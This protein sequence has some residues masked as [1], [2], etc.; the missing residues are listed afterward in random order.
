[1]KEKLC[2]YIPKTNSFTLVS[3]LWISQGSTATYKTDWGSLGLKSV[4]LD[5]EKSVFVQSFSLSYQVFVY[6]QR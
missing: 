1:M 2:A 5:S 3:W 6:S 4:L